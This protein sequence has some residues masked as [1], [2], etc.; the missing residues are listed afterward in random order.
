MAN[1]WIMYAQQPFGSFRV[2]CHQSLAWAMESLRNYS[3]AV[4]CDDV[5]ATL[6]AYDDESWREAR[7]FEST[8]CPFDYPDK[9]IE[10]GPRGALRITN[11]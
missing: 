7:A 9:I 1:K 6:Y 5:T 8:G 11:A 10:R 4:Y 3:R 2:T